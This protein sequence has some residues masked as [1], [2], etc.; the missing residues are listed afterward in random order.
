MKQQV[1]IPQT[2]Y[3]LSQFLAY[4]GIIVSALSLLIIAAALGG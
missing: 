2:V 4:I 1:H 3:D